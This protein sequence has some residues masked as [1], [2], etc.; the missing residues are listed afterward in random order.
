MLTD[1]G[2]LHQKRVKV[3]PHVV[4]ALLLG[5][6]LL[7]LYVLHV[8]VFEHNWL[9]AKIGALLVYIVLGMVALKWAKTKLVRGAAW[10]AGLFVFM[11]IVSVALTKSTLGFIEWI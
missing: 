2:L 1:S 8:S 11:Y 6:A 7:M 3:L 5:S 10:C 9:L 4:D